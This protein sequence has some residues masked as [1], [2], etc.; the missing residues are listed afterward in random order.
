MLGNV[1]SYNTH[2]TFTKIQLL[3]TSCMKGAGHKTWLRSYSRMATSSSTKG[4]SRCVKGTWHTLTKKDPTYCLICWPEVSIVQMKK[5]VSSRPDSLLPDTFC[6]VKGLVQLQ[7]KVVAL[8]NK[9]EMRAVMTE[10]EMPM[11]EEKDG[12]GDEPLPP[13]QQESSY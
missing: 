13:P 8:G 1:E 12:D 11:V 9:M 6:K 7:C 4:L 5:I 3:T 10:M 2:G